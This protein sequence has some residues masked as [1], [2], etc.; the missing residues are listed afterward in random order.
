MV[1]AN[2]ILSHLSLVFT[3]LARWLGAWGAGPAPARFV[4]TVE[5]TEAALANAIRASLTQDALAFPDLDDPAFRCGSRPRIRPRAPVWSGLCARAEPHSLLSSSR[6]FAAHRTPWTAGFLPAKPRPA[7]SRRSIAPARLPR[8]GQRANQTTARRR[9]GGRWR[10]LY[11]G[12]GTRLHDPNAERP[13]AISPRQR[14]FMRPS[15]RKGGLTGHPLKRHF[16][17]NDRGGH[18]DFLNIIGRD[19]GR[20]A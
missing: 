8:P 18:L 13:G 17:A 3:L 7:G 19:A 10:W 6:C 1:N 12:G 11:V 2:A 9:L 14:R 20:V 16:P 5:R 15:P 4:A